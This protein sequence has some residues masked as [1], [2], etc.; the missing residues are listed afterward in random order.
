MGIEYYVVC[1]ERK[2]VFNLGKG[3]WYKIYSDD[4]Y[5]GLLE[6]GLDRE[7]FAEKIEQIWSSGYVKDGLE[8]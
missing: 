4:Y 2:D 5:K 3:A 7:Q 1:K 8:E 6:Q